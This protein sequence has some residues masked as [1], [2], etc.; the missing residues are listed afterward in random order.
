MEKKNNII[1]ISGII[2]VF[3]IGMI[4]SPSAVSA[5]I[6]LCAQPSVDSLKSVWHALCDLEQ[7]IDAIG[8]SGS[9]VPISIGADRIFREAEPCPVLAGEFALSTNSAPILL[10]NGTV[11]VPV[12][13]GGF[14]TLDTRF[15]SLPSDD[16]VWHDIEGQY[17][18]SIRPA[19]CFVQPSSAFD[20]TSVK[21]C[22]VADNGA[23]YCVD[24]KITFGMLSGVIPTWTSQGNV[25][26]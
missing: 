25:L 12:A 5:H 19:L 26:S 13:T 14:A 10:S 1:L 11:K 6:D 16:H 8:S 21:A 17:Q 3:V 18:L 7:Q 23:V 20:F 2:A 4:A 9:E 15:G 22:A 24:A